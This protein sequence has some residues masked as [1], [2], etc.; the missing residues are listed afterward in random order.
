MKPETFAWLVG[1]TLY[2]HRW[3]PYFLMPVVIGLDNGKPLLVNYDSIGTYSGN[4]DFVFQG[5]SSINMASLC[6]SLYKDN[7]DEQQLFD[8]LSNCILGGVDTD[9][10]AGWGVIVYIMTSKG[11][12]AKYLKTKMI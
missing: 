6:E 1:T 10:L 9:I 5:S 8:A 11:I 12:E 3:G 4:E 7:M 2:E